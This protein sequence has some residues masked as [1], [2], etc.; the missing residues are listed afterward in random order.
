MS[1][2]VEQHHLFGD[3]VREMGVYARDVLEGRKGF[4]SGVLRR[5]VDGF[6]GCLTQHLHDV[7]LFLFTVI[8]VVGGIGKGLRW[9]TG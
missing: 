2:N 9:D 8:N 5:V 7:S 6:A 3:G 1:G 4:D